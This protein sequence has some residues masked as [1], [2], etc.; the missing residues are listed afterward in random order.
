VRLA[1]VG[2]HY[3]ALGHTLERTSKDVFTQASRLAEPEQLVEHVYPLERAFEVLSNHV[4]ELNERG[5]EAAGVTPGDRP[6]NLRLMAREKVI[7]AERSRRWRAILASRNELQH[8]YPDVRAAV[9]YDAAAELA[10]DLPGYVRDY[11]RWMRRL[12]FGSSQTP[13]DDE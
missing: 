8:E 1:D 5:L 10:A 7:A 13:R 4:A 11:V 2:R 12:G 9:V 6:T 3:E